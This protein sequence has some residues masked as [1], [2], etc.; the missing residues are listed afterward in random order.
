MFYLQGRVLRETKWLEQF[1]MNGDVVLSCI[2]FPDSNVSI[3]TKTGFLPKKI[4][5]SENIV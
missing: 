2:L 5:L 1:S 3:L 4:F